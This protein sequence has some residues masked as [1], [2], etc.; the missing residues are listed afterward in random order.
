MIILFGT[1]SIKKESKTI[2]DLNEHKKNAVKLIREHLSQSHI[3]ELNILGWN[4]SATFNCL[5]SPN[6]QQENN[7]PQQLTLFKGNILKFTQ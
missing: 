3:K 4:Q 6:Y 1:F 5:L 2:I 7:K